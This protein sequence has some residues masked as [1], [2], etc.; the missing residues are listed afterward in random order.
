MATRPHILKQRH[1]CNGTHDLMPAQYWAAA[2]YKGDGY[3]ST[4]ASQSS[5]DSTPSGAY[6]QMI[7]RYVNCTSSMCVKCP[8]FGSKT[9]GMYGLT[10]VTIAP[11]TLVVM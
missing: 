5:S 1:V 6:V 9:S 3:F 7:F 4:G 10:D 2:Y 8:L 11:S